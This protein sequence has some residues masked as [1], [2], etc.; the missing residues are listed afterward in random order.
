[1]IC[2]RECDNHNLDLFEELINKYKK[3]MPETQKVMLNEIALLNA[4]EILGYE[5]DTG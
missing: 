3:Y 4:N 5:F 1:M 2:L